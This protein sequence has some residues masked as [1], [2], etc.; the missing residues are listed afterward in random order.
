MPLKDIVFE[1]I[2]EELPVG[3]LVIGPEGDILKVNRILSHI[4][5]H[6][7]EDIQ[8]KGWSQFFLD[9]QENDEFNQVILD[10]IQKE[11]KHLKRHVPYNSPQRETRYLDIV[12]SY[13]QEEGELVAIVVL[14]DDV[15][16]VHELYER[17]KKTLRENSR[18]QQERAEELVKLAMSVAHQVRNPVSTIGGFANLLKR[19]LGEDETSRQYLDAIISESSKLEQLVVSVRDYALLSPREKEKI[20]LGELVHECMGDL[21]DKAKEK[22]LEIGWDFDISPC[23]SLGDGRLLKEAV[24]VVMQ[25][26]LDFAAGSQAF[27][28]VLCDCDP[29]HAWI[30]VSDQGKGVDPENLSYLFDPFFTT[31]AETSGMGLA[32]TKKIISEHRGQIQAENNSGQ[33]LKISITLPRG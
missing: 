12:S 24:S 1:N 27:I 5:G 26:C 13:I 33:G 10:V 31:K 7:L 14:F 8:E 3:L 9:E 29:A 17:E 18:L 15:T 28:K 22:G 4:L 11:I 20:D 21:E 32:R 2:V 19:K 30:T 6:P 16:E 25:N 23:T